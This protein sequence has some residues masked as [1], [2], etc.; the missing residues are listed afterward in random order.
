VVGVVTEPGSYDRVHYP[1]FSHRPTRL[2]HL[3]L[4]GRLLGLDPPPAA[5]ARVLEVGC[6]TGGNLLPLAEL[7]PGASFVGIDLAASQIAVAEETARAIGVA[8]VELRALDLVEVDARFGSFDYI[9]AHGV[10]SWVAGDVKGRLLDLCA[11]RLAPNGIA[12]LNHNVKPGSLGR[13]AISGMMRYHTR[14]L[15][16]ERERVTQ[17]RALVRFL[18]AGARPQDRLYRATLQAQLE[19]LDA[20]PD[21]IVL[22][23]YLA[24]ENEGSYLHE[25]CDALAARRLSF[26]CD[27]DFATM[28]PGD[29]AP[30]VVAKVAELGDIVQRQELLD[31]L[32]DR[33]FRQTLVVHEEAPI[34]RAISPGIIAGLHVGGRA[35]PVAEDADLEGAAPVAF[36]GPRS[37]VQV[38][39]PATKRALRRLTEGWPASVPFASLVEPGTDPA[40]LA[41]ELLQL[42]ARDV[43][44]LN[45]GPDPFVVPPPERPR[46]SPLVRLQAA[47]GPA[48]T[49]RRH[50]RVRIDAAG[51]RL[52][53]LLD[54]SRDRAA[55]A[56]E[57]PG[58]DL[59]AVLEDVGRMALF[60]R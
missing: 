9:I 43:V 20:L 10:Y 50:E 47:R 14:E 57:L 31:E 5:A 60:V 44:E 45:L 42:F 39:A 48:V 58:Q 38:S 13:A 15:G 33:A 51:G 54:G 29:L 21:E 53:P 25:L 1:A 12:Y 49:N 59:T 4:L 16:D 6:A 26:L 52:L 18:A 34:D 41:H 36:R 22:Y 11:A 56:R 2:D 3:E 24:G 7:Y 32:H 40:R 19:I 37:L 17:A 28:L 30:E 8:N 35:L 27:A 55:L 23:D 46:V